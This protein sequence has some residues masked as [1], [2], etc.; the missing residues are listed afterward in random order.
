MVI[1]K[2]I[3]VGSTQ[4]FF[5]LEGH[6]IRHRPDQTMN[7][8]GS[9]RD[10]HNNNTMNSGKHS[11]NNMRRIPSS[12]SPSPSPTESYESDN[13][14]Y[15]DRSLTPPR[16]R[17]RRRSSPSSSN[18]SSG[19][20]V[21]M[22]GTFQKLLGLLFVIVIFDMIYVWDYFDGLDENSDGP[23]AGMHHLHESRRVSNLYQN[24]LTELK[25]G[26]DSKSNIPIKKHLGLDEETGDFVPFDSLSDVE[27]IEEL[28][29]EIVGWKNRYEEAMAKLGENPYPDGSPALP[30][31][32]IPPNLGTDD[33]KPKKTRAELEM[34]DTF[35]ADERIVRILHSASVE[36]DK[37]LA[38]QLPTWD[39]VVSLYGDSPIVHG[40]ETCEPYRNAVKPA[41]RMIGPAGMFNTGTNLLF[42]LMKV[43]CDIKAAHTK[44]RE[45]RRNGMRWQVPWG[46]HNPPTTHRFKNVAKAWGKGIKHDDF[47]P[48]VLI[49]DPYTWMGSQCRHKYTTFWGHD[50]QHCPN[51]IR[52][53][54]TDRDEPSEVRVKFALN[55]KV[56]ES[57]L[58]MWNKWYEEWEEQTFPHLTTRFE[59][60]L[61]HGEEVTRIACE[62][63]GG[64]FTDNFEYVED[65][66]KPA[67]GIHKGANGLVK[68]M[69]QYGDPKKRLIGFTDRDRWYASKT[70][71]THLITKYNYPAPPLPT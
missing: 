13:N 22:N 23:E 60:L 32:P 63:V 20:S 53:R 41:D 5:P 42:E 27:K 35:G 12:H 36:I 33:F 25:G 64:D 37:E 21:I 57:L 19:G 1:A 55:M 66:A 39:D 49:K 65:S 6:L 51:L 47:M 46:K 15:I 59:D 45:P 61:F 24:I 58:D 29:K 8:H 14:N 30:F 50:D 31:T 48:V 11:N 52:W 43:N 28:E 67:R 69:L 7:G 54:V 56:Y 2:N 44:R 68:A 40:L 9:R 70:V 10:R 16:Q 4:Q 18:N 38:E 26:G 71:D 62:C 3:I 34:M 17:R